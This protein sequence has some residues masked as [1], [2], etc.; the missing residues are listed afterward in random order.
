MKKLTILFLFTFL[1]ITSC[2][3]QGIPEQALLTTVPTINRNYSN[4]EIYLYI[5]DSCEYIG[6]IYPGNL[7]FLTHK[8]NCKYCEIRKKN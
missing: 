1:F 2:N 8:G 5:I 7:D 4:Q 3:V 6:H